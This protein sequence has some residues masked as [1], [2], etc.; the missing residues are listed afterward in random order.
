MKSKIL[1]LFFTSLFALPRFSVE[2]STSCMNCHINPTGAGMRNDYGTNIYNL[3]E[4]TIRKWISDGN[5]DWDG[6]VSVAKQQQNEQAHVLD[7]NVDYVGRDGISDMDL[8]VSKIVTNV[9]L[10][11]M[12]DSTDYKKMESGLKRIGGKSII[13]STKV[14][15]TQFKNAKGANPIVT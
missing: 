11:L 15:V 14:G 2:E 4:L 13:N 10:P 7:I 8:L 6:L 9:N 3:D 1:I 5:E 12:L